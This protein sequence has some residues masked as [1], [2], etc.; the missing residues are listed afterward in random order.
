[1]CDIFE[2]HESYC[3]SELVRQLGALY[4]KE[5]QEDTPNDEVKRERRHV[6]ARLIQVVARVESKRSCSHM[7]STRKS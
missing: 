7:R 4:D 3:V 2:L 6:S 5:K 1:M